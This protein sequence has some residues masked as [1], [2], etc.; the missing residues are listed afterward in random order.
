MDA[1]LL[2]ESLYGR[3]ADYEHTEDAERLIVEVLTFVSI[4]GR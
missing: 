2:R 3:L 4:Q 1:V